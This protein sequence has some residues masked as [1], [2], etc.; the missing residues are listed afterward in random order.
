M[1][2]KRSFRSLDDWVFNTEAHPFPMNYSASSVS[3]VS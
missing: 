3:R 1:T 2:A